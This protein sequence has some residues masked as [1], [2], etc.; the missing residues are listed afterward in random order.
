MLDIVSYC[1]VFY[2]DRKRLGKKVSNSHTSILS[3]QTSLLCKKNNNV[4][5]WQKSNKWLPNN[6]S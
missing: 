5:L 3:V 1:Q 2:G 6:T 4:V